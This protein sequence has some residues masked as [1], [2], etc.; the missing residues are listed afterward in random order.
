M[1]VMEV[2]KGEKI[3]CQRDK[4]KNW[5]I[6]QKGT[7]MLTYE[8]IQSKLGPNSIIGILEQDWFLC[9]YVACTDM[10]LLVFPC[11]SVQE[12]KHFLTAQPM[13]CL[14]YTSPSPRDRG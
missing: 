10:T 6:I 12:L 11:S 5:Y 3:V 9:D 4:V 7:A 14:L 13:I 2:K 1:E 8:F